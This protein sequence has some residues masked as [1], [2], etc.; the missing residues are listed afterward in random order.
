MAKVMY[1]MTL[2]LEISLVQKVFQF[3]RSVNISTPGGVSSESVWLK[4]FLY[5][6]MPYN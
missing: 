5:L 4:V 2:F 1:D 3:K 6:T